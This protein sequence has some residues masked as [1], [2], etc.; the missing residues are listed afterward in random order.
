LGVAGLRPDE[1][2]GLWPVS[3][4]GFRLFV[5]AGGRAFGFSLR[6]LIAAASNVL[7]ICGA[8]YLSI[9]STLVRQFLA[10]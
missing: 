7:L 3:W 9:I 8:K 10:I 6:T 4:V 1:D 2:A 5:L